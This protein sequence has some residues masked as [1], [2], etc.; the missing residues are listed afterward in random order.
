MRFRSFARRVDDAPWSR[1]LAV[2]V[3]ALLAGL[4][5]SQIRTR[6]GSVFDQAAFGGDATAARELLATV[7][8]HHVHRAG[9]GFS[10]RAAHCSWAGPG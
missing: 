10:A 8:A 2:I 3:V 9:T 6:R 5:L 4:G 1:P 7:A